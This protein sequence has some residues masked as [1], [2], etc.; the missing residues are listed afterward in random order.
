MAILNDILTWTETLPCWQRDATRRLLLNESGLTD[1]DYAELYA[2]LKNEHGIE[3]DADVTAS[4]LAAEHLPAEL[5]TG[6]TVTLLA[7]RELEDVNRIPND[8]TLKFSET[9]MT[10][11]YG[12]NSSG[13][14]GYARVMKRACRARDQSEPIHPNAN[15]PA[16]AINVPSAKFD[17]KVSGI[18]E[19]VLWSRDST[20][21]DRLSTISVF[22]SRCARSYVTAEQ[23]VAYL[24]YGLDILEN[25]ADQVLPKLTETLDAEL[26]AIDVDKLPFDHLLGDTEVGKAIEGLSIDSDPE[27]ITTLGTLSDTDSKRLEELE[28]A[29]K[30]ADPVSKAKELRLS[31]TRLK[32]Y[33]DK[34]AKPLVWVSAEVVARLQKLAEEKLLAE[35]AEST[36][37]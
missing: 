32:S 9:G 15:D 1:S 35:S 37:R 23:D 26:G 12:G 16:A 20:A 36:L 10:V 27:A 30:E 13:K 6:E 29:I 14:S 2:L 11:I 8:H 19:E 34:L 22:D 5:A 21:P 7:L 4:P 3:I 25:L 28:K 31:A 33:G 17:V 18:S 24:P